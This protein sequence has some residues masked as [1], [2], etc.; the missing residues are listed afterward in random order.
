MA[1]RAITEMTADQ[2]TT[3]EPELGGDNMGD[4]DGAEDEDPL[5]ASRHHQTDHMRV[6]AMGAVP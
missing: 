3:D 2:P 1:L 5:A 4:G 6:T